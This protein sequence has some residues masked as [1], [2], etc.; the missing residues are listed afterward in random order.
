[1]PEVVG[2]AEPALVRYDLSVATNT[3]NINDVLNGHVVLEL[4]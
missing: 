1:L 4:H 3:V 2:P